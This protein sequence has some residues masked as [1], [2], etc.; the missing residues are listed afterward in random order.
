[1]DFT[2]QANGPVSATLAISDNAMGSPQT[3]A[4]SG[5]GGTSGVSLSPASLS[6]ATETVGA[7]SAAQTVTVTNTGTSAVAMTIL[8]AGTN[9]GDFAETDNCSQSPLAGGKSC[10][11]NVTFNP[12]QTGSRSALLQISDSAPGSP[13]IVTLGGTAVQAAATLSPAGPINFGSVLAGTASA[14]VTVTV[15][16]SGTAPAILTV[17]SASVT[18]TADFASKN[19]CS[20]GVAAAGSCTL[21]LTFNPAAVA[22]TAPCGSTAGTKSTTLTILDNSPTSPQTIALSGT[23]M[24]YCLALSGNASQTV[25]AGTPATYNL[26]G[27]SVKG[28]AGTVN[29]SCVESTGTIPCTVQPASVSL[30]AGGQ[31]AFAVTATSLAAGAV[32]QAGPMRP[33][34]FENTSR[35]NWPG[36]RV[37]EAWLLVMLAITLMCNSYAK[38][39][40]TRGMRFAQTVGMLALLS[41]GLAACFGSSGATVSAA[42]TPSGTYTLTVTGTATG[43]TTSSGANPTRTATLTLVVQ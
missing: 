29:L 1:M 24:D 2:P 17:N 41:V 36:S 28:F 6:F 39:G 3:V 18:D 11:M 9:P 10:V 4:L 26:V 38:R 34:T 15:T 43:V 32:P 31:V 8:K 42:G 37:L 33:R 19:G 40:L 30:T 5:T 13:Q 22:A 35:G 20:A 25:A 12:T 7:P 16:N 14:P 27:D 23:T 21:T